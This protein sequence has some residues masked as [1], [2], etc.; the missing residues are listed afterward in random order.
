MLQRKDAWQTNIRRAVFFGLLTTALIGLACSPPETGSSDN[1]TQKPGQQDRGRTTGNVD[2]TGMTADGKWLYHLSYGDIVLAPDG[3]TLLVSVPVPGPTASEKTPSLRLVSYDLD[4]SAITPLDAYD[5]VR[6]QFSVDG[7]LAWLLT[8]HGKALRYLEVATG[9]VTLRAQLDE[10]FTTLDRTPDGKYAVLANLPRNDW[11]EMLFNAVTCKISVNVN[12]ATAVVDRCKVLL[13]D[14]TQT[15]GHQEWSAPLPVRD[16]DF[17]PFRN[18]IILTWSQFI[19]SQPEATL[20]F[21][22]P[23]LPDAV[24]LVTAPNCGDELVLA[25]A[26]GKA[27]LAPSRCQ[28]DPISVFDLDKRTYLQNLPGFGPVAIVGDQAIGFT[29]RPTLYTG[30]GKTQG[31]PFGPIQVD[32]KTLAWKTHDWGDYPPTFTAAPNGQNLLVW[33]EQGDVPAKLTRIRV[34]DWEE[35][36]AQNPSVRLQAFVWRPN[37][38]TVIALSKG[39]LFRLRVSTMVV[40]H[41]PLAVAPEL[42]QQRPTGTEILLAESDQPLFYRYDLDM[43]TTTPRAVTLGAQV[44]A[45]VSAPPVATPGWDYLTVRDLSIALPHGCEPVKTGGQLDGVSLQRNV[46]GKWQAV[47]K[48]TALPVSTTVWCPLEGMNALND[49]GEGASLWLAGQNLRLWGT[50]PILSGD[51]I[52]VTPVG[53]QTVVEFTL[54]STQTVE[55]PLPTVELGTVTG[56]GGEVTLEVP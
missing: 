27:L 8:D 52:V 39:L 42:L 20:G 56:K 41:L 5:V 50:V 6:A 2:R 44:A 30:W 13:V 15:T 36:P 47:G 1:G 12:G 21:Y 49:V 19:G 23:N 4:T 55:M 48:F 45:S 14:A 32:L 7:K 16:L 33:Q 35:T 25:P 37:G 22:Q 18:E 51:R 54:A 17:S 53:D 31:T 43:L 28:K 46:G 29:T 24:T 9:K 38:D 40:E 10:T 11:D 26:F 34:A 3:R